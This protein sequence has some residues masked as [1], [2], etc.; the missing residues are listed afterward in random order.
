M[1]NTDLIVHLRPTTP[2]RCPEVID[3]A[4]TS[5]LNVPEATALRSVHRMSESAYKCFER[6]HDQR[7]M[8]L[9][10]NSYDV[11]SAN[12]ARQSFPDTFTANGYVDIL[13]VENIK[14]TNLLHGSYVIGFETENTI[15]VDT[16]D[17]LDL[18]KFKLL[19][20]QSYANIFS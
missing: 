13:S 11:D 8:L 17:D 12:A 7:L 6:G 2:L 1:I 16:K 3:R 10:N 4:I 18:L 19:A 15:E 5:F 20:N 9:G 14:K